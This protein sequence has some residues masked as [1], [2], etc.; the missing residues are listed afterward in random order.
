MKIRNFL[1]ALGL[2]LA[3]STG[4][5]AQ[6]S[7]IF[8]AGNFCG[9]AS[10]SGAFAVSATPTAMFDRAFCGTANSALARISGSWVCLASANNGVW[11]TSAA[12]VP[13][14]SST[15]PNAVQDNITR[16]GTIA[17]IGAPLGATFGGTGQSVYAVGDIL[18][19]NTTTTLS[20]LPDVAT[21][22]AVISG[23]VGVAPAYGKIGLTTHV[24]GTLPVANGGTNA[25][26]ASGTA[27]DNI[28][29][30][31]STGIMSRTGAGA[32]SFSTQSALLDVIGSTRGSVLYRGA[33]GWA[34]LTPGAS[35]TVLSSNGA[36]A[37]PSYAAAGTGTIT[38]ACGASSGAAACIGNVKLRTFTA[39]G[40]YTPDA[41]LVVAVIEC[42]GSGAGGGG[43]AG[44]NTASGGGGGGGAGGYGLKVSSAAAVGASQTV[45]IG[46]AGTGGAAG[47]NNGTNGA[48]TSVGT[49]CS[50]NGGVAGLASTGGT[51]GGGAG[52]AAGTGDITTPGQAGSSPIGA[53]AII[54]TSGGE[55]GSAFRVGVGGRAV[56]SAIATCNNG[57]AG[58]GFGSGGNGGSCSGV[59]ANASGGSG[60]AGYV[61]ITEYTKQ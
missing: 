2:L 31:A 10:A 32:Y 37:D 30:F 7:G 36:G 40:T 45:T 55:G 18:F 52:G 22:N 35:G 51:A 61:V 19:A 14:I 42:W 16:L 43:I 38:S 56:L 47:A 12:G 28:T 39:S 21:G 20:K 57:V 49:L 11:V 34:A 53:N 27:L 5:N 17:S 6:C 54:Q 58:G 13:S 33:A 50:A 46:A 26:S 4:A 29:G 1:F 24:S 48:T 60:T 8:N 23:G 41:N 3:G 9:N 59:T 25:S 15:L 44:I